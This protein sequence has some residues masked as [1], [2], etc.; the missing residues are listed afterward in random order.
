MAYVFVN[1]IAS[2]RVFCHKVLPAVYDESLSYL[3]QLAKLAYK[4][5]EVITAT[6]ALNDN[7]DVLNDAVIDYGNKLEAVEGEI[8]GFE[9]DIRASFANLEAS[10]NASVDAKLAEVDTKLDSVN[11]ELAAFEAEITNRV[12]SLE[13]T[14]TTIISEEIAALNALY[15]SLAD[16]LRKYVEDKVEEAI[17]D[18]PDLTNI[19]V[20]DPTS[21]K[22][23]KVQVAIDNI[24]YF[25]LDNAL[26]I[27]EYN[28]L[29]LT[30]NELN[31]LMVNSIPRGF[32]IKEWLTRARE[33]L[34]KQLA[35][36]R[37][38]F[39]AYPHSA[40]WDYLRGV[41]VWHDRN[42]DV[43][44][45]LIQASGCYSCGELNAQNI[46]YGDIADASVE[47]GNVFACQFHPEKSSSVG[48]KILENFL[49]ISKEDK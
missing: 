29:E 2:I 26:T 12:N 14:L 1:K 35:I 11:T 24:F 44:Q 9:A 7:V 48:L 31:G 43:N 17:S 45:M 23:E 6:N 40:V 33:F 39:L 4:V 37:V 49:K 13:R 46:S 28:R 8:T 27:D 19:Y 18:I 32:S 20:I 47:K 30:A 21:G 3:E 34:V 10:I 15:A 5:D 36:A 41:K 16:N 42:V 25:Q 22:L 38:E